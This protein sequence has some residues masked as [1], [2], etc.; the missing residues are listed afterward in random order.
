[1]QHARGIYVYLSG[2]KIKRQ[3][4]ANTEYGSLDVEKGMRRYIDE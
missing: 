2:A 4:F 1:L 3:A